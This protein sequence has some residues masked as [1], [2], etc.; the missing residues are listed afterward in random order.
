MSTYFCVFAVA[1]VGN[2]QLVTLNAET[3]LDT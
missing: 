3:G 1:T 2:N